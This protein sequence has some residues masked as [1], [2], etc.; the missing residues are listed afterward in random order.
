MSIDLIAQS[1]NSHQRLNGPVIKLKRDGGYND[2]AVTDDKTLSLV[3]LS[4]DVFHCNN[5]YRMTSMPTIAINV[6]SLVYVKKHLIAYVGNR[7]YNKLT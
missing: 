1:L 4:R 2:Y 7:M 3:K 5:S 6:D